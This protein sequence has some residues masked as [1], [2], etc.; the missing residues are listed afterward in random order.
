MALNKALIGALTIE[1][2][3]MRCYH[4]RVFQRSDRRL[5]ICT[6]ILPQTN[7]QYRNSLSIA[8]AHEA[9]LQMI[10]ALEGKR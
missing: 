6:T 2:E 3:K 5:Q 7:F 1:L 4:Y 8:N 10:F 9:P